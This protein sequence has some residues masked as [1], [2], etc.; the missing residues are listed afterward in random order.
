VDYAVCKDSVPVVA[1]EC[2]RVGTLSEAHRGELKGY[3]NA[4]PSVKL[5]ILTDGLVFELYSDTRE[6]NL[7]D[8]EPFV[9]LD[10]TEVCAGRLTDQALDALV[11]LQ[12]GTFDPANVGSD[13]KKKIYV[14]QYLNVLE[15][16]F[17]IPDEAFLRAVMDLGKVEGRRTTKMVEEHGPY[18]IQAMQAFLD[19][20]ILERVG[21]AERQ[22]LVRVDDQPAAAPAAAVVVVAEAAPEVVVDNGIVTT[23]T[24]ISVF[25][26]A[27]T[28]LAFLVRDEELFRKLTSNLKYEDFKTTFTVFYKA[29]RKGRLFNFRE[30]AASPRYRFEFPD[31][32]RSIDTD[33]LADID[34]PLLEAFTKRVAELG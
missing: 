4:V 33:D 8:D 17:R 10:L 12:K 5:G 32:E 23:E 9:R 6:P 14:G 7:M 15:Q 27:R 29:V 24:E 2:K 1:I 3:F 13:A 19:K 11:R 16:N 21:F 30:A 31:L 28:R 18:V 26:Y 22:D 25:E 20:K 34:A